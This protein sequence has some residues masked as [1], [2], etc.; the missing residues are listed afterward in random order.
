MGGKRTVITIETHR[1]AV[2]RSR[3]PSVVA[4]CERCGGQVRMVTPEEAAALLGTRSRVIY[5]RVESGDLHFLETGAG[6]LLICSRS[7]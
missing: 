3:R 7:L 2:V 4:W 5:R 1:L 6:A